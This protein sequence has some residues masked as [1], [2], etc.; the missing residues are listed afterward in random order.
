MPLPTTGP[1]GRFVSTVTPVAGLT[2]SQQMNTHPAF[3]DYERIPS[4]KAVHIL[5][6]N[7]YLVAD[8]LQKEGVQPHV[9]PTAG[10]AAS[11]L[12]ITSGGVKT[13]V[14]VGDVLVFDD[15]GFH[16][17]D[18]EDFYQNWRRTPPPRNLEQAAREFNQVGF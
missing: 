13:A 8:M 14:Q 9:T 6:E 4:C 17:V 1:G 5:Q 3:A 2:R 12:T 11:V 15:L 10:G 18:Q 7:I 16:S